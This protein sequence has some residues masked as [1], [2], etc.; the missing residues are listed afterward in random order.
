MPATNDLDDPP[1]CL[2]SA[3]LL[4]A[5]ALIWH[6]PHPPHSSAPPQCVWTISRFRTHA[7][8]TKALTGINPIQVTITTI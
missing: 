2:P 1:T 8:V 3:I 4:W 6:I 7:R 5:L